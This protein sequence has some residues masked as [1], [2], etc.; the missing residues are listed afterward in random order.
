MVTKKD[1]ITGITVVLVFFIAG[2]EFNNPAAGGKE[3]AMPIQVT[4]GSFQTNQVIPKKFTCDGEN[5]S[6]SLAWSNL[7][8]G[9]KSLAIVCEDPDA[10]AGNFLHWLIFNIDPV[11][12]GLPEGVSEK[13][14]VIG[15]ALQGKNGFGKVGYG[16][17]C[18]P[19]GATHRYFFRI[20]ALDKTLELNSGAARPDLAKAMQGH[21]LGEG[22]LMGLYSR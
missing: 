7:P 9:S 19:R 8:V 5:L 10:P 13:S 20:Y 18:P 17:P 22:E 15:L 3:T 1:I 12:G 21:V 11:I 2:C 16:G 14:S 6:P 4:S